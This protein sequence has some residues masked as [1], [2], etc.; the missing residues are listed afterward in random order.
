MTTTLRLYAAGGLRSFVIGLTGVLFGLYLAEQGV[1][2]AT[3]GVLVG[4]GLAGTAIGTLLVT[5]WGD[6]LGRRPALLLATASGGL[7]VAGLALAQSPEWLGLI[8]FAGMVNGMGRDRG[9]GQTL[10]QSALA[11]LVA[12]TGRVAA[13]TRYT[14]AQDILG[15]LGALAAA[16]PDWLHRAWALPLLEADRWVFAA[17]GG[18]A[19]L[20]LGLYAGLPAAPA[21]RAMVSWRAGIPANPAS[22]RRIAGL[23]AL[24]ALDSLGG[25]LIPGAI[26][27][28]WFFQR[29]GVSGAT[30]GVVFFLGRALNA[31]SYVVA[32]WLTHRIGH[33]RAMVYTHL[34]SS[35]LL[36]LLPLAPSAAVAVAVYLAR[37]SLVQMD[38]PTRQSYIA[39]VTQPGERTFALGVTSLVRNVGWSVGPPLSGSAIAGLGLAAPLWLGAGLKIIYDLALF[40]SFRQVRPPEELA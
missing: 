17:A 3:V 28:Y 13:F 18:I 30:L 19:L 2:A 1:G 7:G 33:I 23:A 39:A 11:D 25:G 27:A 36:I 29:F 4:A 15:A 34:P 24:I 26:L 31:A 32:I 20:P 16:V 40:G 8:A 38:V 9:P 5:V 21:P 35:A 37:E 10:E 22:R 6:R 14:L 12:D